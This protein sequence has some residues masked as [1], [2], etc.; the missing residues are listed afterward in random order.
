MDGC[1]ALA[2]LLAWAFTPASS[3]RSNSRMLCSGLSLCHLEVPQPSQGDGR[4]GDS[5][6]SPEMVAL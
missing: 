3:G 1:Y 2:H 5:S 6:L 4:Y